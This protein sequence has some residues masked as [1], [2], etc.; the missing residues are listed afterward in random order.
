M[1]LLLPSCLQKANLDDSEKLTGPPFCVRGRLAFVDRHGLITTA[2]IPKQLLGDE[3]TEQI[4]EMIREIKKSESIGVKK[5]DI[6]LYSSDFIEISR[7]NFSMFTC[8]EFV[9]L[10][11]N[12]SLHLYN[13]P[14][15]LQ[16]IEIWIKNGS[17]KGTVSLL[18]PPAE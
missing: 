2:E 16:T 3:Q 13:F 15:L 4:E 14:K 6:K 1:C 7:D 5:N 17:V 9:Y 8:G 18:P 11:Q 12:N 10:H